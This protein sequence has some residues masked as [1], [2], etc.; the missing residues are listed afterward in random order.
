MSPLVDRLQN[1][2]I[3]RSPVVVGG[4]IVSTTLTLPRLVPDEHCG[5]IPYRAYSITLSWLCNGP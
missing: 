5:K 4:L 2:P 3:V 1:N